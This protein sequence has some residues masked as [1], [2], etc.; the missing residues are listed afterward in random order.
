MIKRCIASITL[1]SI[2][3]PLGAVYAPIPEEELGKALVVKLGAGVFHD[4]NIFGAPRDERDSMVYRLAPSISYN[5]SLTDQTFLSAS[6]DM[7]MDYVE[8]RPENDTL[9]THV[10]SAR[11]AHSFNP[12]SVLD[13]TEKFS[14]IESPESLLPGL[15]LN[16]DQSYH[17]N[18]FDASYTNKFGER[19]GYELKARSQIFAYEVDTLAR[20]LDRNEFLVGLSLD[21]DVSETTR[22]SGEYRYQD[23]G[24]DSA[25]QF[26]D[27]QSHFFLAGFDYDPS[28]TV[29]LS[30]RGGAG[31]AQ[32]FRCS[33][34]HGSARRIHR[35]LRLRRTQFFRGRLHPRDRGDFQRPTLHRHSG[36]PV[37]CQCAARVHGPDDRLAVLQCGTLRTARPSRFEWRS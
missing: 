25:G 30:L 8:D 2:A 21:Y 1:I 27:K 12:D 33:G 10:L 16:T 31:A 23:V 11:L 5:A 32:S 28:E 18:Q 14:I 19:F 7:T 6:Y 22:T 36:A 20:Q 24:Y 13:V 29:S 3:G 4:S 17:H 37:F 34:R 15:P 26:K 35:P 9:W